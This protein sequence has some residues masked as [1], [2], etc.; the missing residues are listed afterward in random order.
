MTTDPI[1][2]MMV[3]MKNGALVSKKTVVVPFSKIKYAIAQCLKEHG[4][5]AEVAKKTE[6]K[7]IPVLELTLAYDEGGAK[8]HDVQRLSKPSRRTYMA[9]HDIHSVKNGHGMIVLSTPKG[10]MSGAQARKEVVGGEA[11]F[12]IW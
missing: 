3:S 8:I 9:V 6:K 7:N 2:N 10:I 11:L 4:Y 1:A 12:M 5:I